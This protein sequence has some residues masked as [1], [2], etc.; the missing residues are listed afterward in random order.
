VTVYLFWNGVAERVLTVRYMGG[1]LAISAAFAVAWVAVRHAAGVQ[2][3]GMPVNHAVSML[4]PALL[5]LM[6]SIV[7]PWSLSRIRHY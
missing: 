7:A 5:P 6:L 1:A 4:L 2:F 3:H